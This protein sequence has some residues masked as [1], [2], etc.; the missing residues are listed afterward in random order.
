LVLNIKQTL[1]FVLSL[2]RILILC[3]V[4]LT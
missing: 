3:W 1:R 2:L 4:F